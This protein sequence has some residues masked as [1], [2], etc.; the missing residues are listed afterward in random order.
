MDQIFNIGR[1]EKE[2]KPKKNWGSKMRV[3]PKWGPPN[4][5]LFNLLSWTHKI[6]KVSKV[7]K[8]IDQIC[9]FQNQTSPPNDAA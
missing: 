7:K 5:K 3:F 4:F 2:T 6:F 1:Y 9:G 8:K